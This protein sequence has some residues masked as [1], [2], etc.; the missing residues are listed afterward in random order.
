[1]QESSGL[2]PSI[3]LRVNI[4][5]DNKN[6]VY[7]VNSVIKDLQL[8]NI[9]VYPAAIL[10]SNNCHNADSCLINREFLNFEYGFIKSTQDS[11]RLLRKYPVLRSNSCCAD[12]MNSYVVNADGEMY[13]CWADIGIT[14]FSLG[15]IKRGVSNSMNEIL[16][17]KNDPTY[18]EK[19]R[20]CRFLPLCLGGC[21]H[22]R[23][24]GI[25]EKLSKYM[26]RRNCSGISYYNRRNW[27]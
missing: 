13:K 27:H 23:R 2:L 17:M 4:D 18:D 9:F 11:D 10:N 14:G 1:M 5:K 21:P 20:E 6:A 22:E 19:C 12:A 7:S 15:N 25:A 26:K 3:S 24:E 8:K 16:Y